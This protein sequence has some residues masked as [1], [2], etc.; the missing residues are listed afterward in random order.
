MKYTDSQFTAEQ[1]ENL[2]KEYQETRADEARHKLL[3]QYIGLIRYVIHHLNLPPMTVLSYE[4]YLQIGLLGLN[5][6]IERYDPSRGVKFETYAIPRI[7]GKI[8]DEVRKFDWLSRTARKRSQ[9]YIQAVETLRK[10]YKREVTEAEIRE[11][12]KLSEQ[13]YRE[14]LRAA[15]AATYA[16]SYQDSATTEDSDE[17][18]DPLETLVAEEPT[19]Q[20]ELEHKELIE[21]VGQQI[22]RLP[23]RER[24]ILILYYYEE[25][26]FREIGQILGITESRISQIHSALLAQLRQKINERFTL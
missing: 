18:T 11:H 8:L 26:T 23:E 22:E 21:F 2:W 9:E 12:L 19:P 1:L 20:Q 14:Y 15:A 10:K 3:L 7:R 6:A 16:I 4:D 24:T 13:E 25:L 5:E 17:P